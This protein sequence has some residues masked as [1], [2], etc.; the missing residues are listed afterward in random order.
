VIGDVVRDFPLQGK[1]IAQVSFICVRPKM[2]IGGRLNQLGGDTHPI[3]GTL[4][5]TLF[6]MM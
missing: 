5:G 2:S 6:G 1:H 3:A 4:H